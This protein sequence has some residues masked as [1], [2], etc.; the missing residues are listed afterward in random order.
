VEI[1]ILLIAVVVLIVVG[2][3]LWWLLVTTEGVY[4]G[5]RVVVWLYDV[6]ARRYDRIKGYDTAVEAATIG[7]PML[8]ALLDVPAPLVLDVAT[9]TARTHLALLGQP[10]FNGHV[11]GLDYSRRMLTMA[12]SKIAPLGHRA[13]LIYQPA[14]VLPFDD[15]TFDAVTCLEAL[16]FMDDDDVVLAEI[17]RVL[18]PGGLLLTTNRK[19]GQARMMP[20]KTQSGKEAVARLSSKFGLEPVVLTPWQVEYD[21]IWAYKADA[22][23]PAPEH[24]LEAI[25]RCPGC[26]KRSLQR[27]DNTRLVCGECATQIPIGADGV[28]EYANAKTTVN[29]NTLQTSREN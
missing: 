9:G 24:A 6:Y 27:T 1:V 12:A 29:A 15:E 13:A 19:G 4:L 21:L 22:A 3:F 28:I 26:C 2:A 23:P 8:H 5:R 10:A 7:R 17:V 14:E 11:I 16:E 20:G 25:L 18:R